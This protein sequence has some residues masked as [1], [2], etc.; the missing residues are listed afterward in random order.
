V[1]RLP[2]RV[3][4]ALALLVTVLLGGVASHY[5]S[6]DPDGL[7]RV[8]EDHGIAATERDHAAGDAPL[9]GY[10][11]GGVD[12]PRLSRGL[13]GLAGVAVVL[14]LGTGL[15]YVVRRRP[16]AAERT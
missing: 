11:T 15:S 16:S 13:A 4:L 2:I 10:D 9:A 8:A 1:R 5:A 3:V 14:V 12:D 6:D 7:S